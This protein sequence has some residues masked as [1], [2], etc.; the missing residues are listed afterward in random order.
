MVPIAS[1]LK[2]TYW[3][4]RTGTKAYRSARSAYPPAYREKNWRVER[5]EPIRDE[6][7]Q[8]VKGFIAYTAQQ[9]KD[10]FHFST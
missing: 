2:L 4:G 8:E 5:L 7:A 1:S 10:L 6:A 9:N 3:A